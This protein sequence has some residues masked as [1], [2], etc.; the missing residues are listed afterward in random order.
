MVLLS[1][2]LTRIIMGAYLS[3][4]GTTKTTTDST[5][6]RKRQHIP[7]VRPSG[8]QA[9]VMKTYEVQEDDEASDEENEVKQELSGLEHEEQLEEEEEEEEVGE[10]G[11]T[12]VY[13]EEQQ[14]DVAVEGVGKDVVDTQMKIAAFVEEPVAVQPVEPAAESDASSMGNGTSGAEPEAEKVE[15]KTD[16]KNNET[17]EASNE[18]ERNINEPEDVVLENAAIPTEVVPV[19]TEEV[20]V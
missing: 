15:E 14:N 2:L 17:T 5:S 4:P 13:D 8:P 9:K 18:V 6:G 12:P 10:D 1:L 16:E 7:P 3:V 20:V 19:M 11:T